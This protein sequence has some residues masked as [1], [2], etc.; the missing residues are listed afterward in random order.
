MG[1]MVFLIVVFFV[2]FIFSIILFKENSGNLGVI[3]GI[4]FVVFI[5][6]IIGFLDD[7]LKIFK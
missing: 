1:G 7:F 5:Y 2:L 3:F 6:G 4:L